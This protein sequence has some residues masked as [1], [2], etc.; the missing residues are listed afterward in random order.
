M[1]ETQSKETVNLTKEE[2]GTCTFTDD[3]KSPILVFYDDNNIHLDKLYKVWDNSQIFYKIIRKSLAIFYRI[4]DKEKVKLKISFHELFPSLADKAG[5][6]VFNKQKLLNILTRPRKGKKDTKDTTKLEQ[7]T[8]LNA[9]IASGLTKEGLKDP[10]KDNNE[11][12]LQFSEKYINFYLQLAIQLGDNKSIQDFL[13]LNKKDINTILDKIAIFTESIYPVQQATNLIKTVEE[14]TGVI[15]EQLDTWIAEKEKYDNIRESLNKLRSG[16]DGDIKTLLSYQHPNAVINSTTDLISLNSAREPLQTSVKPKSDEYLSTYN[17]KSQEKDTGQ[18]CLWINCL[19]TKSLESRIE[20][21]KNFKEN[22][23]VDIIL[24]MKYNYSEY[25]N[26]ANY[27]PFLPGTDKIDKTDEIDKIN[28]KSKIIEDFAL[29][30]PTTYKHADPCFK[31]NEFAALEKS[32]HLVKKR[33]Q[34][35]EDEKEKKEEKELKGIACENL[36]M[37]AKLFGFN[38][39]DQPKSGTQP[40]MKIGYSASLCEDPKCIHNLCFGKLPRLSSGTIDEAIYDDS[41]FKDKASKK[42]FTKKCE[43]MLRIAIDSCTNLAR[44]G[45]TGPEFVLLQE[46]TAL[47]IELL[48]QEASVW[49]HKEV[50]HKN[51]HFINFVLNDLEKYRRKLRNEPRYHNLFSCCLACKKKKPVTEID[52]TEITALNNVGITVKTLPE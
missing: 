47:F 18:N 27:N 37:L 25:N 6:V 13:Q 51:K 30:F 44:K 8:K 24:A 35:E 29:M 48:Q 31:K 39:F 15:P 11:N 28:D 34:K 38:L 52:N 41:S 1:E 7:L 2:D 17:V 3:L 33:Q 43:C 9:K 21:I 46:K 49:K 5:N 23:F 19:C 42:I 16:L 40:E 32:F 12:I 4:S 50:K 14:D 26:N 10:K 22:R 45:G 20:Q 36:E